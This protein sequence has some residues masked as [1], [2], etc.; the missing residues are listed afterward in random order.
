MNILLLGHK[1][2]IGSAINNS[3]KINSSNEINY[4]DA[5]IDS[6][7]LETVICNIKNTINEK[8]ID[9]VINSIAMANVDL[10]ETEKEVCK[11]VNTTFVIKLVDVI[12]Q[13]KKVKLIHISTNAVYDGENAPYSELTPEYPVNYY[14][15]CK[16]EADRYIQAN[17]K[18][19][20]ILRPITLYGK[21]ESGQ[22]HNPVTFYLEKIL[23]NESLKLVDDNVVNML[24]VYDFVLAINEVIANNHL[25]LFNLSGDVSECRYSLGLRICRLLGINSEII[26]KVSGDTFVVAAKR[27]KNTS[28][29]NNKMKT[30]LNIKPRDLDS[31]IL[32][33]IDDVKCQNNT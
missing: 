4:L 6:K 28:F 26:E 33:I 3:L 31:S 13:N 12:N 18:N 8:D 29:N 2:F 10:C 30:I 5:K 21:K 17:L 7:N 19:Y 32:E 22:R 15:I 27:P 9:V 11:L 14:G 25:G 1:G 24:H 23:N 16:L 20:T